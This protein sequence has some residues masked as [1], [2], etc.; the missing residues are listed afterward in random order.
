MLSNV[1]AFLALLVSGL[2]LFFAWK[3]HSDDVKRSHLAATPSLDV[4]ALI[5]THGKVGADGAHHGSFVVRVKNNGKVD[6][7][8]DDL[9]SFS[10]A[11]NGYAV[12]L[13]PEWMDAFPHETFVFPRRLQSGEPIEF[14]YPANEVIAAVNVRSEHKTRDAIKAII[15]SSAGEPIASEPLEL[16]LEARYT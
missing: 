2:A 7:Y 5:P 9:P 4:E 11:S 14:V 8:I 13:K 12:A 15:R 10:L 16:N 1:I 3:W 6:V